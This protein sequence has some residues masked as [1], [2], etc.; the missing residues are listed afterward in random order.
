MQVE[1][2]SSSGNAV[3]AVTRAM[4]AVGV[5]THSIEKTTIDGLDVE[6]GGLD[7]TIFHVGYGLSH[8]LG[9]RWRLGSVG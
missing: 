8:D 5:S 6:P 7:D 1:L 4:L 3:T 2:R 9:K